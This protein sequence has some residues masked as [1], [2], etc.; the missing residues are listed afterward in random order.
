MQQQDNFVALEI[1]AI[2][3]TLIHIAKLD[4]DEELDSVTLQRGFRGPIIEEVKEMIIK[5]S[6]TPKLTK[7]TVLE[8][9]PQAIAIIFL[10]IYNQHF[11]IAEDKKKGQSKSLNTQS[12]TSESNT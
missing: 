9:E 11:K 5:C 4:D 10:S 6:H 7:K 8:V 3:Q 1:N 12:Q 2:L